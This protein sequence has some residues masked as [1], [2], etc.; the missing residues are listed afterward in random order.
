MQADLLNIGLHLHQLGSP[1]LSWDELQAFLHFLPEDSA[2]HLARDPQSAWH[3]PTVQ[4][5]AAIADKIQMLYESLTRTQP[6]PRMLDVI[7]GEVPPQVE[8][9]EMSEAERIE[10]VRQ[11][12][13]SIVPNLA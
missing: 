5:G 8:E 12:Y 2:Y 3:A 4:M 1:E 7:L 6:Q 13:N 9:P 10:L 11:R